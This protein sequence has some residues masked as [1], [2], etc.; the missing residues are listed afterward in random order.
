MN[1]SANLIEQRDKL[2]IIL[3]IR[4]PSLMLC[5]WNSLRLSIWK[6]VRKLSL[7]AKRT[8]EAAE[9]LK[10]FIYL[11]QPQKAVTKFSLSRNE[12]NHE[13]N[14]FVFIR[15]ANGKTNF[16]AL[17]CWFFAFFLVSRH[18]DVKRARRRQKGEM[19]TRFIIHKIKH[20][21][22]L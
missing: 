16:F 6:F 2:I 4:I 13:T 15:L 14:F 12:N 3:V 10:K 9:A 18:L 21:K 19:K 1:S 8:N 20:E 17:L 11:C 5:S 22:F 7:T